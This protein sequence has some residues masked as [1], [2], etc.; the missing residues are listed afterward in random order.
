MRIYRLTIQRIYR[1]LSWFRKNDTIG[2][3][4]APSPPKI[5][6]CQPTFMPDLGEIVFNAKFAVDKAAGAD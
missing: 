4:D 1:E 2:K 3:T 5:W 6:C